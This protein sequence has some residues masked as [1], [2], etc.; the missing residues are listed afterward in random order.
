MK[1]GVLIVLLLVSLG[2]NIGFLLHWAWPRIHGGA[3]DGVAPGWHD[4][5]MKRHL[6]LSSQQARQMESERR[7]VLERA[8]PLQ[9]AL[10]QKRRELFVLLKGKDVREA[11]L[12][13]ILGEIARL[14]AALDKMFVLHSLKARGIFSP[15]QL[16]K[17]EGCLE[18]GLCPGKTAGASCPTGGMTGR[19]SGQPGCGNADESK[20]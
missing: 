8:R 12:D 18:R 20:Q 11:D 13:A 19:G 4:G 1:R 9:E 7:I 16:R 3:R 5:P 15:A 14:Q 10:S 6:G 17:Y 2:I